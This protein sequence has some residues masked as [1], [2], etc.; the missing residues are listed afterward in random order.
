[1]KS[2]LSRKQSLI[3]FSVL[4]LFLV[5]F[6]ITCSAQ[7]ENK[8]DERYSYSVFYN[9]G[10]VWI[11]GGSLE[12]SSTLDTLNNQPLIKLEGVGISSPG[13][14]WLFKLNDRYVSW[15]KP[16]S[17]LPVKS[18]KKTEEGGY[19]THNKYC[20]NYV[21]SVVFIQTYESKKPL[22]RD[23]L[24]LEEK[25][26]DARSAASYLRFMDVSGCNSGDTI[27]LDI[28][29]DGDI[30]NQKIVFGGRQV[31]TDEKGNSYQTIKFTAVVTNSK[32]FSASDAIYVWVSDDEYRIPIYIKANI[33]VGTI[34]AFYNDVKLKEG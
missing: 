11:N 32:L 27:S 7:Q 14:N 25:L 13:W 4:S 17:Y 34:R 15:S 23:T 33:T 8:A 3:R 6:A 28:L 12:L 5:V 24:K 18:E 19:F 20:F 22:S 26:F 21:D 9:W 1:M 2:K 16:D 10:V 31:L 29:M 30:I